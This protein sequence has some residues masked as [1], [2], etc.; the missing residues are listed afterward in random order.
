MFCEKFVISTLF[1]FSVIISAESFIHIAKRMTL[2]FSFHTS[3][4]L[5]AVKK[6]SKHFRILSV[7]YAEMP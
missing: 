3:L 5:V 2:S 4:L 1:L 7:V 6:E